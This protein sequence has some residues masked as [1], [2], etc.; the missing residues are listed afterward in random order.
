MKMFLKL[1]IAFMH[2]RLAVIR[3]R[4]SE[5]QCPDCRERIIECRCG[6]GE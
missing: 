2:F 1:W 5:C 3:R 6:G 4:Q